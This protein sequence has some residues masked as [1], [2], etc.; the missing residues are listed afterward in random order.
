MRESC[1]LAVDRGVLGLGVP[2]ALLVA[3]DRELGDGAQPLLPE[4]WLQVQPQM[5][6]LPIDVFA[7]GLLELL[8]VLVRGLGE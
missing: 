7:A 1:Q 4:E 3:V 6:T 5:P 2:P 8:D